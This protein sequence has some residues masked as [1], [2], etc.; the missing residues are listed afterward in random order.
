MAEFVHPGDLPGL[1]QVLALIVLS[2]APG[3]RRS[4][5]CRLRAAHGEGGYALVDLSLAFG[6]FGIGCSVW[7]AA[8]WGK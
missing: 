7:P 3:H 2:K 5:R 6:L 4:L 8:S 1:Q